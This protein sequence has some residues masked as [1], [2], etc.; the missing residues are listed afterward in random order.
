MAIGA[1]Q[2][3]RPTGTATLAAGTSP[4]ATALQGGGDSVLVFNN[5]AAVA[6]IRFGTDAT[7]IATAA[8][9]PIPPGGRMLLGV[10]ALVRTAS[11]ILAGGAGSV[12][13]TRGD[14]SVY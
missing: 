10:N 14:G 3:F 6:F 5:A 9:T 1:S 12:F 4:A 13:F 7:V 2:P 11:A 8:D